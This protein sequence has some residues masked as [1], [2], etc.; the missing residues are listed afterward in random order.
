MGGLGASAAQ[1]RNGLCN[2]KKRMDD[3]GGRF[4]VGAASERGTM[5]RLTVPVRTK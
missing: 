3:I 2:M 4:E 5:V 1:T